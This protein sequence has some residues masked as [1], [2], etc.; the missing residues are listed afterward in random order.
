VVLPTHPLAAGLSG[1]VTINSAGKEYGWCQLNGNGIGVAGTTTDP[2]NRTVFGYEHGAVLPAPYSTPAPER[3]V[4][5]L[6]KQPW[7]TGTP[8]VIGTLNP[9]GWKLFD[10]AIAWATGGD[11][12]GDGLTAR[13]ES[14]WGTLPHDRDSNDNGVPD[15]AEVG[16]GYDGVNPDTDGDGWTNAFELTKGTSPFDPDTDHDGHIDP[17]DAF[18]LDPTRWGIPEDPTPGLPPTI[19]LI[20]PLG[21]SLTQSTCVP[22][23]PCP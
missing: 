21:A 7:A 16:M 6:T 13:E 14:F 5:T 4:G 19:T 23:S 2:L 10:A 11:A 9:D 20:Q 18:P 1:S 17:E 3:R 15:G 22:L 8:G 12:D